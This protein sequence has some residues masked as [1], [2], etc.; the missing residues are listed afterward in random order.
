MITNERLLEII[1]I[2]LDKLPNDLYFDAPEPLYE[3]EIREIG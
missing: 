1:K 2:A 3:D